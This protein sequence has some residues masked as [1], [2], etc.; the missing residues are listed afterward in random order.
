M[1]INKPYYRIYRPLL[2]KAMKPSDFYF[3]DERYANDRSMLC[4]S[5]KILENDL[6]V[7]F[8]YVEPCDNN[9]HTTSFRLYELLLRSCT[10]LETN[11]KRILEANG[12]NLGSCPSMSDYCKVEYATKLSEY[13]AVLDYWRPNRRVLKPFENWSTSQSLSWYQAYNQV[14]HDR[15]VNFEKACLDNVINAVAGVLIIL[16]SQFDF[17][18]LTPYQ[19]NTFYFQVEGEVGGITFAESLFEI[20]KPEW[21]DF[22]KYDFDWSNLKHSQDSFQ[23]FNFQ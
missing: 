13:E 9:L 15:Q 5:Y 4:R 19:A 12:Y 16:N 7:L 10:E 2:N 8:E 14:K 22:N 17:L 20:N 11:C 18:T 1:S 23:Q 6:K 21:A 3:E